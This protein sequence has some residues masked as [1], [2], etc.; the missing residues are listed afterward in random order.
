MKLHPTCALNQL[1]H[2]T[3]VQFFIANYAIL[4]CSFGYHGNMF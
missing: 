4:T 2:I 3:M 1:E